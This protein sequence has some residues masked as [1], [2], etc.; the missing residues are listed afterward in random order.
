MWDYLNEFLFFTSRSKRRSEYARAVLWKKTAGRI[1]FNSLCHSWTNRFYWTC[2]E[3]TIATELIEKT[4]LFNG[5]VAFAKMMPFEK[6]QGAYGGI[7]DNVWLSA[8]VSAENNL[9]HYAK[10][11]TVTLS[12]YTGR[13]KGRFFPVL[14]ELSADLIANCA[15]V[16]DNYT[17]QLPILNVM[18]YTE[19]L[20][21]IDTS[22]RA[23]VKNILGTSMIVCSEEQAKTYR[24]ARDAAELGVPYVLS[25]SKINPEELPVQLMATP[26]ASEELKTLYEAADKVKADYLQ[27]IGIRVNNE[28]DRRSGITPIEIVENRQNIDQSINSYLE[29]RKVG[30]KECE[31]IGLHLEVSTKMLEST[32]STYDSQ[33]N[34]IDVNGG[35]ESVDR[36]DASADTDNVQRGGGKD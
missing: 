32:V 21:E 3:K 14:Q 16:R 2:P 35:D 7:L 8:I 11:T 19:R 31:R 36:N 23:C 33:G 18:Y 9:S 5:S 15:I 24:A 29:A 1:I 12:D 27:S 26:G 13:V 30:I 25:F 20:L 34:K 6:G 17:G 4:I 10:P 28:M 22:I